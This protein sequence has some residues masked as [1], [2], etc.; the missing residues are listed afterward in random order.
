LR[1]LRRCSI[2][3]RTR[4]KVEPPH[5]G[6]SGRRR[7]TRPYLLER[8]KVRDYDR[9]RGVFDAD[10]AGREAAGCRGARI[11]RDAED[12]EEVV[13]LFEWDSLESARR[14]IESATLTRKFEE[15]G[16][17]GGIGQTEFYL[18]EEEAQPTT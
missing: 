12:P 1:G 9:W 8:H 14:R 6:G 3:T 2:L 11:F 10:S 17:S 4:P 5:A 7:P 18:L 15:A 16:F 13:V